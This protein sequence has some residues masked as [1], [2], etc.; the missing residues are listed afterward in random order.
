[1]DDCLRHP[2]IQVRPSYSSVNRTTKIDLCP[3]QPKSKNDLQTRKEKEINIDNFK[4][5]HARR[6]WKVSE[7]CTSI[8]FLFFK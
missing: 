4:N 5:F 7:W 3:P 8:F 6:R 1:M 2:W